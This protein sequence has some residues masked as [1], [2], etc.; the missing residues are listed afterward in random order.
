L[1]GPTEYVRSTLVRGAARMPL[2]L[3]P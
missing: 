3:S 2:V 1:T